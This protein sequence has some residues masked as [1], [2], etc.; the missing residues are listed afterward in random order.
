MGDIKLEEENKVQIRQDQV[1]ED[2]KNF[3]DS[4]SKLYPLSIAL[5]MV[6]GGMIFFNYL[7]SEYAGFLFPSALNTKIFF[8]LVIVSAFTA[9][10]ISG[11]FLFYYWI[12]SI[13][14]GLASFSN[15]I[16]AICI[17]PSIF[18]TIVIYLLIYYKKIYVSYIFIIIILI[19]FG[20][21]F[22][23]KNLDLKHQR[24]SSFFLLNIT[25][26][27]GLTFIPMLI[28]EFL[29]NL[30]LLNKVLIL[31]IFTIPLLFILYVIFSP[32]KKQ[33]IES[34]NFPRNGRFSFFN[35]A[36]WMLTPPLILFLVSLNPAIS[37]F[38]RFAANKIGV[39]S[40]QVQVS[41][42][43]KSDSKTITQKI[44]VILNN[45]KELFYRESVEVKGVIHSLSLNTTGLNICLPAQCESAKIQEKLNHIDVTHKPVASKVL[46]NKT[47]KTR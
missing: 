8:G 38:S 1:E 15:G 33:S 35:L 10:F 41:F 43:S 37:S 36:F 31:S 19:A 42:P 27:L 5:F 16:M 18:L 25:V 3:I 6:D 28:Y 26:T 9:L 17:C 11:I 2:L 40:Y 13:R 30:I 21:A 39:G 45:G 29:K 46:P 12:G 44:Y 32:Y 20:L 14:R 22:T 34:V 47:H 4:I 24:I 7:N 23:T